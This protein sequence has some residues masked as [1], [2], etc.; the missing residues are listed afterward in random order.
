MIVRPGIPEELRWFDESRFGMFV[1]FGLYSLLGRGEW[2]MYNEPIP[3]AEYAALA[4][5]FNPVRF[6]A[7]EWVALAQ[8]AGARYITVTAKHHDG[9]CLFDSALTDFK[10]TNTPFGRDLIGELAGACHRAGTRLILYYS[11]PD[12]HHPNYVHHR[13]A[14]K[15]LADPPATDVPDWPRY[16]EYLEGQVRELCTRYGRIDGIWWDGSHKTEEAWRGRRLYA[17]IKEHQPHAVVND[18]AR[19]GDFFTPERSLPEDLTGYLF[20]ACESV[21]PTQ[22][23]YQSG[24]AMYSVPHLVRSL[25]KMAS[26]GGNYLLNVGP[27][28]DGSI[29][30]DQAARMRGVGQWLRRHGQAIC[31]TQA[32]PSLSDASLRATRRGTRLYVHLLDWPSTDRVALPGIPAEDIAG[33]ALPADGT[34]LEVVAADAGVEVRG[35]PAVPPDP[36]VN[37]IALDLARVTDAVRRPSPATQPGPALP[38]SPNSPTDLPAD[39]AEL[40]GLGVKGHRLKVRQS[41]D[42]QVITRWFVP[43]HQACWRL[44]CAQAGIYEVVVV[45]RGQGYEGAVVKVTAGDQELTAAVPADGAHV[46]PVGRA[47]L[48]AGESCLVLSPAALEWGYLFPDVEKVVLTPA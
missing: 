20:E 7:E 19:Y 41:D 47:S 43:E 17:L 9:F 37:V 40:R 38:V 24:S 1:H 26:A 13:G 18:R 15:D 11:Q 32:G 39:A 44:D 10:I 29:P 45:L 46:L 8:D 5:R 14:Y 4:Q 30:A 25:V 3:R 6:D 16:Q 42:T 36:S 21:S 35:L 22:W 34:P 23:G 33:A 31:G 12:W 27:A 2:V 28:P 48:P